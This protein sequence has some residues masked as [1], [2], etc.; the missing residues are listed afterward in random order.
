MSQRI[1]DSIQVLAD[2]GAGECH[3]P[4]LSL[5]RRTDYRPILS[6]PTQDSTKFTSSSYTPSRLFKTEG[7]DGRGPGAEC[8]SR[9]FCI[10]DSDFSA[11][12]DASY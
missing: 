12:G 8:E 10:N 7:A 9:D 11:I 5:P 1:M 3:V 2:P 4:V 6:E